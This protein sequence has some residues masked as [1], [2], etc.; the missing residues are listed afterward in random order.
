MD[1]KE[2]E[3]KG[4][5]FISH[6]LHEGNHQYEVENVMKYKNGSGEK[7]FA[8]RGDKLTQINSMSLC[9]V[10][11]EEL[12]QMLTEENPKLTVYSMKDHLKEPV[13]DDDVFYP[14]SKES[15]ILSFSMEMRKR[16]EDMEESEVRPDRENEGIKEGSC[17]ADEGENGEG[18]DLVIVA[19]KKTSISVIRGRGCTDT[20][21][22]VNEVVLVAQSSKVMLVARGSESFKQENSSNVMIEHVASHYYLSS[23]CS[24][25]AI[26][27]SPNPERI[28]IYRYKSNEEEGEFRGMPV[29]LNFT[30]SNCFLRCCQK[31]ESVFLQVEACDKGRL[32]QISKSDKSTL[33]FVFY[34]KADRSNQ[35]TFE[36]A[37]H[38]GWFIQ[39]VQTDVV[40]MSHLEAETDEYSFLFVIK[41]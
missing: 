35:R 34:M 36:S 17:N 6:K 25:K 29:V 19:M 8:R 13:Q 9:D 33:S 11:P 18:G 24:Q 4:G 2:S 28:T 38:R 16:D 10:T 30:E 21:C 20:G 7:T 39:V 27:T 37:L 5:L 1:L 32:R 14:V 41:K 15:T 22:T 40:E 23:L 31:D 12:A 3:V 26:S